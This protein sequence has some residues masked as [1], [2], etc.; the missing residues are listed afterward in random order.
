MD[1]AEPR[2]AGETP[3]VVPVALP[4]IRR[5]RDFLAA[6][7][8]ARVVTPAFILLVK[9][10]SEGVSRV[11]FTVSRK[12]GNAVK[13]NRVKRR[14]RE[15]VRLAM[16][17]AAVPASDHVFIARPLPAEPCF[18]SLISDMR[19]ALGKARRRLPGGSA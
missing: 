3:A 9:P 19:M 10:N 11:G 16:G 15:A 12:V 7:S 18:H 13:R 4:R 2:P 8:G 17:G 6:N 1:A 14:L 5:R